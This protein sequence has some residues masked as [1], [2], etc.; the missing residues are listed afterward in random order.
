MND[1][2]QLNVLPTQSMQLL[3]D[4]SSSDHLT[5]YNN[6]N[7]DRE[8]PL[9]TLRDLGIWI[10]TILFPDGD[11]IVKVEEMQDLPTVDQLISQGQVSETGDGM[12]RQTRRRNKKRTRGEHGIMTAQ[13]SQEY[14]PN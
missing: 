11:L 7:N 1:Q 8:A 4:G 5:N 13:A 6:S 12:S 3:G 14:I 2:D 10:I 9:E